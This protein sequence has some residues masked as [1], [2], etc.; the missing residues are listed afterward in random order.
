MIGVINSLAIAGFSGGGIG[1]LLQ[2][3]EQLGVFTYVLP[4]LLI[5]ALIFAI[6][7]K[8]KVF[9]D[10]KGINVLVAL[11][12]ALM[13]L[14]FDFVSTFFSEVFPRLGIGLSIILVV[15]ILIGLFM[16]PD[17]SG[18]MITL[19]IVGAIIAVVVLITSAGSLGWST[20][21]FWRDSWDTILVVLAFVGLFVWA[22]GAKKDGSGSKGPTE[23]RAL[24]FR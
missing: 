18:V 1:T 14:Q 10:N 3:W 5:F 2:K 22:I 13:A 20:G 17:K 19:T 9:G 12:V 6:I 4:F 15:L 23:W 24:G 7:G 21:Q 16:D 8:I 11:V